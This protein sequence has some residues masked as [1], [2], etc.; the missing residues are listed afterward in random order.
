[1]ASKDVAPVLAKEFV[2][3][4]L[5]FDRAK[6]AKEIEKR[7]IDKEQG[8]PWF[9]FLDGGG[10]A[11]VHSTG[12]KGNTGFPSE[13]AEIAHFKSMLEKEKRHLTDDNIAFLVASLEEANK[14]K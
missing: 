11:I 5:D 6:G 4:K 7:Y 1:M 2:T 9:V 12:P 8:L 3:V 13:P 10:K 14:K